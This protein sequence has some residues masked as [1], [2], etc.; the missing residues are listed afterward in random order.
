MNGLEAFADAIMYFESGGWK[1]GTKAYTHRNPGNLED[2]HGNYKN[3]SSFVEGYS[4]L[5]MDLEAKFTGHT[6]TGL[7]P[8]STVLELMMKYAPPSDNNPTQAYTDFICNWLTKALG[9]TV[10][11]TTPLKDIWIPS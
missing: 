8:N 4:A 7:G 2:G 3:F 10:A 11:S 5:V 1:P 6:S 9:I